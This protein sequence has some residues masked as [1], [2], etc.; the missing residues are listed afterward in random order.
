[1]K[2]RFQCYLA[3]VFLFGF[4]FPARASELTGSGRAFI[5]AERE[6]AR[7]FGPD[8]QLLPQNEIGYALVQLAE[9]LPVGGA[10]DLPRS[11]ACG[12]LDFRRVAD[13]VQI[14]GGRGGAVI[15]GGGQSGLELM[16]S[17]LDQEILPGVTRSPTRI[18]ASRGDRQWAAAEFKDIQIMEASKPAS[19]LFALFNRGAI[20]IQTDVT[21]CAWIAGENAFGRKTV[22]ANARVDDS[23]FLWFGVNW[24][25]ADYNAHWDPK[26]AQR[27]WLENAQFWFNCKGGGQGTRIYE[28]IE[29]SYGNPGPTVVFENVRG[30]A[31]YHGSTERAS[32]QGPGVYYLK[33]CEGMQ[34]GLRGINAFGGNNGDPRNADANRDITIE[35]GRGNIIY[36]QRNWSNANEV[37]LWNS[38]P[39]LQLWGVCSQYGQ[40]GTED[41]FRFATTPYYGRP[42]A[43]YLAKLD[44]KAIAEEIHSRRET[45]MKA[46][47]ILRNAPNPESVERLI[48]KLKTG[49]YMDAPF[50][51]TD[52]ETLMLGKA[53]FVKGQKPSGQIPAPPK[54]PATNA[55]R[56]RRPL[57]FAESAEFGKQLLELGADPAG[58]KP[59]DDAFAQ[60]LYG[61][62]RDALQK[63]IDEATALE[64]EFRKVRDERGKDDPRL[65][66]LKEKIDENFKQIT[67]KVGSRRGEKKTV[68]VEIPPG[69]FYLKRP[70]YVFVQ[71]QG[72]FGAGTDKTILKTDQPI[73]VIKIQTPTNIGNFTIEGG[74][75]GL[76]LTGSDHDD[77]VGPVLHSY[78]AGM[79]YYNI[80]FRNQSFAGMHVGRDEE[81]IRGGSEHDQNKYVDLKF[82]NTGSYGIYFNVG[83]LDKWLCLHNEFVGQK[84]AGIVCQFNNLIHGCIIGSTFQDIDGPAIDFFGGNCEIGY[85]PWEV[86]IDGCRFTECGN[87][88]HFA[89]EQGLTELSAF[90]HNTITT[91][92]KAIAGGYAGSPQICEDNTIDVKLLPGAP[93]LKLRA[94]RTI[95]VTRSNGHVFRDVTANGP[96]VFMNDAEQHGDLFE[97]TDKWLVAHG[98][99]VVKKW[100]TNPMAHELAPANGWVHPFLF[101]ECTFGDQKYRYD[102]L[103]VDVDRGQV[104]ERI[105]LSKWE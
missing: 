62:S 30:M 42:T 14:T 76:A 67:A 40:H 90:T 60:L 86:W 101:Y 68:R 45:K 22:T 74:H 96:V 47:S 63:L 57:A 70:L 31:V 34:L 51:A 89:V 93:A 46:N 52:E 103:N 3:F 82:I 23:L 26:N 65:K 54:I 2:R 79:N 16:Y 97:K 33:N 50:N 77:V 27:D 81:G 9:S 98:R 71:T 24:P 10:I 66:L 73:Q 13:G 85:R 94:V 12:T 92:N 48:E 87:E 83:M 55:P 44:L 36:M 15:F 49:R 84:K 78:V 37:S 69:T 59:S 104:K 53:D 32:S 95:S 72:F 28:M 80:T 1:M 39:A 17:A 6:L 29:T 105:D 41:A 4:A 56:T 19:N 38:D 64:A 35:G 58:K 25:F 18:D 5:D 21:N 88:K 7:R 100:D 75:T 99:P 61:M 20:Q 91:K 102:L 43:E 11:V 8:W